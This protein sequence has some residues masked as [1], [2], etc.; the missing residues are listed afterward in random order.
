[1]HP[2]LTELQTLARKF[3]DLGYPKIKMI[4]LSILALIVA[5]D[6]RAIDELVEM[7]KQQMLFHASR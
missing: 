7:L 1:M 4:L 2:I 3:G 5:N 6:E